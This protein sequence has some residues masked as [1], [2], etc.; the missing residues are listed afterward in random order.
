MA[1]G[2]HELLFKCESCRRHR[3]SQKHQRRLRLF[4]AS[5]PLEFVALNSLGPLAKRKQE[6]RYVF[7]MK[8]LYS[9][10]TRAIPIPKTTAAQV[11]MVVFEYR[12]MPYGILNTIMTDHGLQFAAKFLAVLCASIGTKLIPTTEYH[13]QVNG[14]VERFYKT[15]VA[16]LRHHIG[17]HQTDWDKYVQSSNRWL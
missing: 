9:K 5:R 7:V 11:D 14:Q 2:V 17:K 13:A 3:A 16:R 12:L 10:L 1:S 4:P 15:L 6:N 8:D